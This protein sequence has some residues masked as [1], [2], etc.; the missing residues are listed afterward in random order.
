MLK[1][2]IAENL[3]TLIEDN[4]ATSVK[5]FKNSRHVLI[6]AAVRFYFQKLTLHFFWLFEATQ[7]KKVG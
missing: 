6:P 1:P 4:C 5:A 7:T 2:C 3:F